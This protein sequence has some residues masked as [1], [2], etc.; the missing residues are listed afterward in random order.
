MTA[1]HALLL[2]IIE[3]ITEFL[4]I[5]STAHLLLFSD[6]LKLEQTSFL[7]TFLV[8]IQ[9]GAILSV[10]VMYW[11]SLLIRKDVMI[12]I[13]IA[14]IPTAIIGFL[15]EKIIRNVLFENTPTILGSLCIGGLILIA[16][17][18]FHKPSKADVSDMSTMS[19]KQAF[20][21]GLCQALAV[22][23]GVSRSGATIVGG[24]LLGISRK[25]IVDFSFV[26]AVPTM[27]AATVL[28]I[29]KHHD[30]MSFDQSGLLAIGFVVSFIVALASIKWLLGYVKKHSFVAFGVYRIIAALIFWILLF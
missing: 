30:E 2:G 21:V 25:A 5:S 3:G 14:F 15:L 13:I 28:E 22:V 1:L 18:K 9:L 8:V 17:E 20:L 29:L 6:L 16:F 26:L 24:T 19:Y 23:P 10:V 4:P 12:R 7:K 27:L 11:R